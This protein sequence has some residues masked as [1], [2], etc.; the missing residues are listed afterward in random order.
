MMKLGGNIFLFEILQRLILSLQNTKCFSMVFMFVNVDDPN[1]CVCV[2][3][4]VCVCG[5]IRKP[6]KGT[7]ADSADQDQTPHNVA[8]D[9]GLQCL[10]TGLPSQ[11]K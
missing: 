9:Q 8:S 10:L 7:Q 11:I 5:F 3:V 2:C 4:F 6:V 1:L